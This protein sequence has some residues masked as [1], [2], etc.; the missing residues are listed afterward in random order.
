[1]WRVLICIALVVAG[2]LALAFAQRPSPRAD[3]VFVNRGEISSVDPLTMSWQQDFRAGRLLYE[4]LTTRDVFS[5][6]YDPKPAV[7][8]R[9]TVSEDGVTFTFFLRA[10]ARWSNG[11]PVTADDFVFAWRRMLLPEGGADYVQLFFVIRGAERFHNSRLQALSRFVN[12]V[13]PPDRSAA[14]GELWQQAIGDFDANVGVKAIDRHTLRVELERPTP[15]FLDLTSFGSFAPVY[16][17]LVRAHESI[18]PATGQLRTDPAWTSPRRFVGNGPFILESW[19]FKR[20]VRLT[21]APTYWDRERIA[22]RSISIPSI[23]D[24]SAQ[25]LAFQTGAV[26][27]VVDATTGYSAQMLADRS[28]FELEHA[29]EM[30]SSTQ[31]G[32]DAF[33]QLRR[34]PSDPRATIH[35]IPTF[36]TYF[37]NFACGPTLKD[38]RRNPFSD[39]RV[40]RAF[41][42]AIDRASLCRTVRRTGELPAA[43][44]IPPN[45]IAEYRSPNGL[46]YNPAAARELLAEAGFPDG[47]GLPA[48]EITFNKE[49]GNDILAQAVARDWEKNLG[50][51]VILDQR[52][53][54]VFREKVK[55]GDFMVSRASWF[56]DYGDPTTFLDINRTAN[57]NNDRRYS[58]PA[59]DSLLDR[60]ATELDAS[61][62]MALLREAERLIVEVDLPLV[63]IFTW[64]QIQMFDPHRIVGLSAHPRQEQD[65]SRVRV[66]K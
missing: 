32:V 60:A 48:I 59:Y 61:K 51:R 46:S 35:S 29:S 19:K 30:T 31:A 22:I 4:G 1:M 55:S 13:S 52:E 18:D 49:G 37:Y 3:F 27:W 57:G 36:G 44:L 58:S 16:P 38:G 40:R 34:L 47:Q 65:L 66:L 14:A 24:P 53:L 41:A 15:Y 6:A 7:A 54:K 63:P 10:D 2:L 56:G 20:E 42:I 62:R 23:E 5:A 12:E 9:W 17:P 45:S 64:S 50:V 39:A 25:L 33:E 8:E 43:T 11:E 21:K 26:D 28:A